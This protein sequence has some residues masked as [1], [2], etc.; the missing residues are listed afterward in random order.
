[1]HHNFLSLFSVQFYVL[2]TTALVL[3][4][5]YEQICVFV[6]VLSKQMHHTAKIHM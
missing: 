6:Y 5:K 2:G 1:M 3:L 4:L